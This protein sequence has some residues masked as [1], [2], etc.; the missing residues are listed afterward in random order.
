ML[1]TDNYECTWDLFKSIPSLTNPG[2]TVFDETDRV[3]SS[4]SGRIPW[5]AWSIATARIVDGE[6][7]W[8]SP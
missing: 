8:A 7:R 1:T 4:R 6:H 5:P 3:Q 2:K